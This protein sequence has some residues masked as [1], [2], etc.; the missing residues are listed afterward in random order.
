[1]Q[2]YAILCPGTLFKLSDER[3]T[4]LNQ[5][6]FYSKETK[7]LKIICFAESSAPAPV[8]RQ[9]NRTCTFN[10]ADRRLPRET[11]ID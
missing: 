3:E 11:E 6:L 8:H 5:K 10:N 4:L 9:R 1:M 7:Y 2:N